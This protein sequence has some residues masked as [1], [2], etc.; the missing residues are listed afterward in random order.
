MWNSIAMW[1]SRD[2]GGELKVRENAIEGYYFPNWLAV[3]C[4]IFLKVPETAQ[5]KEKHIVSALGML[6]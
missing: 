4:F 3:P 2:G 1:N 5:T 6:E